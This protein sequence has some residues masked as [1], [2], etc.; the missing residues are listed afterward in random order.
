MFDH[1]VAE[2]DLMKIIYQNGNF[3]AKC[4]SKDETKEPK[5]KNISCSGQLFQNFK[6]EE[7]FPLGCVPPAILIP[8][9]LPTV[10]PWTETP[11]WTETPGQRDPTRQRPLQK[12][13]G[14]RDRDHQKE[15]FAHGTR[16][17]KRKRHHR[18]TPP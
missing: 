3:S 6:R 14:T 8:G 16:Q 15:N 5:V 2:M 10:I 17:P 18:E 4:P 9:G 1:P 11:L 7:S 12:D 13:H